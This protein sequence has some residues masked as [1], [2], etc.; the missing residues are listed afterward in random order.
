MGNW[1]DILIYLSIKASW[2]A[3]LHR[4]VAEEMGIE[5]QK[6]QISRQDIMDSGKIKELIKI[7]EGGEWLTWFMNELSYCLLRQINYLR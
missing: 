7:L 2:N 5:P 1:N 3:H 4:H 6:L